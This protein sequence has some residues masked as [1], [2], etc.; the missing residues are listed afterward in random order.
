ML[1]Q[2]RN[3]RGSQTL[4]WVHSIFTN[5][6]EGWIMRAEPP[7]THIRRNSQDGPDSEVWNGGCLISRFG[8]VLPARLTEGGSSSVFSIL[9][10][11]FLAELLEHFTLMMIHLTLLFW[12][13]KCSDMRPFSA[14]FKGQKILQS[15]YHPH[16]VHAVIFTRFIPS[17]QP[18]T[19][20][21]HRKINK[22]H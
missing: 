6:T 15:D 5:N 13:S 7:T 16:A 12:N 17:H 19:L 20:H 21:S 8:R 18:W 1:K 9:P 3:Q 10:V 2:K 14:R 11:R 4:L 22:T